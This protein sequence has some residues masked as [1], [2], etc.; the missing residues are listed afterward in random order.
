MCTFLKAAEAG[1]SASRKDMLVMRTKRR[2]TVAN[3]EWRCSSVFGHVENWPS[4][5][6]NAISVDRVWLLLCTICK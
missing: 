3:K 1:V 4:K 5:T 6:R 2:R